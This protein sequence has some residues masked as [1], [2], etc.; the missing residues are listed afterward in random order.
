MTKTVLF[1]CTG[2]YYRSRFSEIWFNHLV[3]QNG[4][5]WQATS[6]G[7]WQGH[8]P[9]PGPISRFTVA[10][11]AARNLVVDVDSERYPQRPT[12]ADF[13]T[14][15]LVI[16]VDEEEHRPM[17]EAQFP[18]WAERITYWL[19]HDLHLTEADDALGALEQKVTELVDSLG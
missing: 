5:A 18:A 1:L 7:L 2:N 14:A 17:M 11:L 9:N 15:D 12:I 10:G 6:R 13:E 19:V 8:N 3:A 16:A 4:L